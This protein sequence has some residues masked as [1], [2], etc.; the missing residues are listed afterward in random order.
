M[1]ILYKPKML[2]IECTRCGCIYR[3][4]RKN[5]TTAMS[6]IK[7]SVMCPIC[8]TKNPANFERKAKTERES[9]E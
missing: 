8:N 6:T 3:P 7:D 9:A 2:S 4:K 5:L 1:K